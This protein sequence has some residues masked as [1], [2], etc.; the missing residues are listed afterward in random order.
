MLFSTEVMDNSVEPGQDEEDE[1]E[2]NQWLEGPTRSMTRRE[3]RCLMAH[4]EAWNK[5]KQSKCTVAELFSPPRFASQAEAR[6]ERGLSFDIQQGW[7]LTD[8]TQQHLVSK[9]LEDEAPELLVCCPEC[10][11]WGGWYRL[12]KHKFQVTTGYTTPKSAH[13]SEPG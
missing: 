11:H 3:Q 1:P 10:K 6:G 13:C 9:Q 7:D 2:I 4:S 12:N 5:Q 8:T